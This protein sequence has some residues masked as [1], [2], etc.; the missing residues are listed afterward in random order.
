MKLIKNI[1]NIINSIENPFFKWKDKWK[2]F[3]F[4]ELK[5]KF[6]TRALEWKVSY[7]EKDVKDWKEEDRKKYNK[8]DSIKLEKT[9]KEFFSK[10]FDSWNYFCCYCWKDR[11][12]HFEE[13]D[14][15]FK[16]L[17]DIEHFL[18]RKLF[19]DLS[20]NLLNWLPVCIS[21]NQR[22]KKVKNPL[23]KKEV[24]HPYFWFIKMNEKEIFFEE[25]LG[26]HGKLSLEIKRER[27]KQFFL[28]FLSK[29][30]FFNSFFILF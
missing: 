12:T 29:F 13:K 14:W 21:C 9:K 5:E 24:F 15:N 25:T 4:N 2:N 6:K 11:L 1:E 7:Y 10:L 20:V 23:D 19:P 8:Y 17:Y 30:L 16:R 27:K 18:P 3:S 28:S 26:K 22:L